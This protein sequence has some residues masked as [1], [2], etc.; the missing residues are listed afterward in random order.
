MASLPD[1]GVPALVLVGAADE[2]FLAAS[3]YMAAK[4]PNSVGVVLPDA[5]PSALNCG[6]GP[7]TGTTRRQ[8]TGSA[9]D[10]GWKQRRP[11]GERYSVACLHAARANALIAFVMLPYYLTAV[12]G[13]RRS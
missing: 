1:I 6:H 3:D 8:G 4:I 12:I 13:W 5:G 11:R 9:G 7:C 2:P 10:R